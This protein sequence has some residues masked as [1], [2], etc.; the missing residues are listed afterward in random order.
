[1]SKTKKKKSNKPLAKNPRYLRRRR[2]SPLKLAFWL[3]LALLAGFVAYN[4]Y[5]FFFDK[6]YDL[7]A[8]GI[9]D[10]KPV[11]VS[12][13]KSSEEKPKEAEKEDSDDGK[14]IK[15]NEGS[16]PNA[17]PS[18]T[19]SLT[20]ANKS[21]DNLVIRVNIDQYLSSG[22]CSLKLENN[23]TLIEKSANI[24]PTASTSSCEGF[25]VPLSELSSGTWNIIINLA[26]GEKTGEIKGE[27]NL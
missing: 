16:D 17:S 18:L 4:M 19:G 8:S 24:F 12:P 6:S 20:S 2:I 5:R 26:S 10:I 27:V 13:E 15:Q 23:G 22:T 7:P 9:S 3:I 1:M 11:E 21:G 25:D 14:S